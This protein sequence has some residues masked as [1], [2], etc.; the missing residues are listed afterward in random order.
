MGSIKFKGFKAT[1]SE[2]TSTGRSSQ[3]N[4]GGAMMLTQSHLKVVDAVLDDGAEPLKATGHDRAAVAL[5]TKGMTLLIVSIYLTTGWPARVNQ[6]KLQ[7]V[8]QYLLRAGLPYIV[9]GDFNSTP[10]EFAQLGWHELAGGVII[11]PDAE[12]TCTTYP[13][14]SHD[15][16]RGG[17][18][19]GAR[20]SSELRG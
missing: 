5:R 9:M 2:A 8:A 11:R 13:T 20:S 19:A 4:S 7:Q 1:A 6:A 17:H 15:R 3:G 16:L 10:E 18:P 12:F 14:S